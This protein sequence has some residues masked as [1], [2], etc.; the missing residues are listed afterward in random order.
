M[1]DGEEELSSSIDK[2]KAHFMNRL[3]KEEFKV[4]QKDAH[5]RGMY[6]IYKE[7]EDGTVEIISENQIRKNFNLDLN[8]K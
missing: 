5:A 7:Y 8:K 2:L 3:T 1:T 4:K 6:L